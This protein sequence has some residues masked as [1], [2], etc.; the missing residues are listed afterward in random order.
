MND[1][2]E[3]LTQQQMEAR[4]KFLLA[5]PNAD[6]QAKVIQAKRV[7]ELNEKIIVSV[8]GGGPTVIAW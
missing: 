8:S 3:P 2:F 7:L 4:N 5:L 6:L 1:E